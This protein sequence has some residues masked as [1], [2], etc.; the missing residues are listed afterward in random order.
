MSPPAFPTQEQEFS[1]TVLSFHTLYTFRK[2]VASLVW[3]EKERRN[4]KYNCNYKILTLRHF[5]P[6]KEHKGDVLEYER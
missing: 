6:A 1:Q 4:N 3:P 2:S 5:Q